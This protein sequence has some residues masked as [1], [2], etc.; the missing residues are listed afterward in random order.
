[1]C[2]FDG[3]TA[4]KVQLG[5][6]GETVIELQGGGALPCGAMIA[7]LLLLYIGG[8]AV[9][10]FASDGRPPA[11]LGLALLWP[12]GPL[13]FVVTISVLIVAAAIA[14]PWFGAVIAAAAALAWW[15]FV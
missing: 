12:L 14:F 1:M 10:L 7:P 2:S 8:V 9:G 5:R 13:A 6:S 15:M 11:R 4:A 3:C